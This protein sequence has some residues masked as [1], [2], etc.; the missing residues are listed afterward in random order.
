[1]ERISMPYV[2][3]MKVGSGSP[4]DSKTD[5]SFI[6]SKKL[7]EQLGSF[8]KI[9]NS[10]GRRI[11]RWTDILESAVARLTESDILELKARRMMELQTK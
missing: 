9:A 11:V 10:D 8:A 5:F 6:L 1:M 2:E 3:K 4:G 7:R